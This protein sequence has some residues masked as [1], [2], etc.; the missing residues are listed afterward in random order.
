M[1]YGF[2]SSND[3]SAYKLYQYTTSK[4]EFRKNLKTLC[5]KCTN[6]GWK[7]FN[8]AFKEIAD[9]NYEWGKYFHY[10]FLSYRCDN[11]DIAAFVNLLG[12]KKTYS[13]TIEHIVPKNA[14][15]NGSLKQYGFND[16]NEFSHIRDSFGNLLVLESELN[17]SNTDAGLAKKQKN[18]KESKIFYNK[19]FANKENFLSFN[20]SDII[21]ENEKFT[22]WAREFF[23]E[24]LNG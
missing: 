15:E 9:G 24:F 11:M 3:A 6:G 8:E 23:K 12:D 4:D 5:D 10:L 22:Q 19:E 14:V 2:G 7:T 18:Y 17:S 20:K 21:K 13:Y 1:L 16:E